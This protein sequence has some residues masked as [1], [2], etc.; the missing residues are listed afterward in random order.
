MFNVGGKCFHAW[1]G[2]HCKVY[3]FGFLIVADDANCVSWYSDGLT[4]LYCA[5]VAKS[6][7][8]V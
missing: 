2:R 5:L 8:R 7:C 6:Y 1:I 3:G 4:M